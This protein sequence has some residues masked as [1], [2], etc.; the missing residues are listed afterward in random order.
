[1]E[2]VELCECHHCDGTG[3]VAEATLP[4]TLYSPEEVIWEYCE[5]CEGEGFVIYS[6]QS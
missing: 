2:E 1:M 4:A 6:C 5:E 3:K